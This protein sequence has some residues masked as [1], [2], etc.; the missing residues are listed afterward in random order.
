MEVT[1]F[2]VTG[3]YISGTN[4]VVFDKN[5][6]KLSFWA[7]TFFR[8]SA[9]ELISE[10]W[11]VSRFDRVVEVKNIEINSETRKKNVSNIHPRKK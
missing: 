5:F 1:C 3:C 10:R 4:I 8:C 11:I 6:P 9:I 7:G 2:I